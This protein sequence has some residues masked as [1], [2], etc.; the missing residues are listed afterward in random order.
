MQGERSSFSG[1]LTH[2]DETLAHLD[3]L[4]SRRLILTLFK[5][6]FDSHGAARLRS[7]R[8]PPWLLRAQWK[9]MI[10]SIGESAAQCL[11]GVVPG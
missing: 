9:Q 11:D 5:P 8:Q 6:P 7:E 4:E 3:F 2:D 1:L 10:Q